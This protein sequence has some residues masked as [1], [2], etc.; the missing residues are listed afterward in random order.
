MISAHAWSHT[1]LPCFV[2]LKSDSSENKIRCWVDF[3]FES[4]SCAKA[5]LRVFCTLDDRRAVSVFGAH[6]GRTGSG[7]SSRN[8]LS[9]RCPSDVQA[10]MTKD[11]Q[12]TTTRVA[13]TSHFLRNFPKI[14]NFFLSPFLLCLKR[15]S[16]TSMDPDDEASSVELFDNEV[17]PTV[18]YALGHMETRGS[19]ERRPDKDVKSC[20][21]QRQLSKPDTLHNGVQCCSAV[22][23]SVAEVLEAY[24]TKV[25]LCRS[26]APS[27]AA[28]CPAPQPL[29]QCTD[30][31]WQNASCGRSPSLRWW[32]RTQQ[33]ASPRCIR[34]R[35][36]VLPSAR[37]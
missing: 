26:E 23:Q 34:G 3:R 32:R 15:C 20:S 9:L 22:D 5:T 1:I 33:R 11:C 37:C 6:R 2:Q 36:A 27:P 31:F 25:L 24:A 21:Q 13:F 19:T 28:I 12:V 29:V 10:A 14:I 16:C 4:H 30:E 35:D 8:L 18:D 7:D 17:I